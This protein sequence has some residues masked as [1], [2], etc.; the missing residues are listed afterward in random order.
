MPAPTNPNSALNAN[1]Q[2][3]IVEYLRD[4]NGTQA[5]IRAGY[6]PA[7]APQ[8][9]QL[10][11]ANPHIQQAVAAAAAERVKNCEIH[12]DLVLRE[13]LALATVDLAAAYDE[14]G[15]LKRIHD[16]PP[17][18]RKAIAGVEVLEEFA[19]EPDLTTGRRQRKLIGHTRKVKFWDR[20]KALEMLGRY[21]ALF[22]DKL[23][24]SVSG[25]LVDRIAAARQREQ[26]VSPSAQ[27][28]E[29]LDLVH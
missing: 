13:L 7:G 9:A 24:L 26:L 3:F 29:A 19:D 15:C 14:D 20:T 2:L 27:H 18:V 10:L 8:Q 12:A 5:A 22:K 21:L 11:L 17:G 16:I 1:Q 4:M 23:D 28:R 6:S 25:E